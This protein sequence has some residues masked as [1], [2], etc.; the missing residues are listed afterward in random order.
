MTAEKLFNERFGKSASI[1]LSYKPEIV[2]LLIEFAIEKCEDQKKIC[3]N[4]ALHDECYDSI[5]YSPT[6]DM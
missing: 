2:A 4:V 3:F 5:L 1:L 6:P